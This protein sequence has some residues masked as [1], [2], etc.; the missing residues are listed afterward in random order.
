MA[1]AGGFAPHHFRVLRQIDVADAAILRAGEDP[2]KRPRYRGRFH[3][4]RRDG[5]YARPACFITSAA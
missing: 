2:K 3:C 1:D 5:D 4:N